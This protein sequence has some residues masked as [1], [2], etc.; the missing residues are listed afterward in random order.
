MQ[1]S[2][3]IPVYNVKPYLKEALDSV[4]NQTHK[5][6]EII[7]V[8][9]GSTDGSEAICKEY[10]KK[11][12]RVRLLHQ[13]NKGLSAARNAGLAAMSSE[14][15]AFLDSDDKYHPEYIASMLSIMLSE[16]V[17]LVICQAMIQYTTEEIKVSE[18]ILAGRLPAGTYDRVTSLQALAESKISSTAWN[19]LYKKDLFRNVRFHEGHIYEDGEVAFR[20]INNCSKVYVTNKVLYYY[21]RRPGSITNSCLLE[22]IGDLDLANDRIEAFIRDYIPEIFTEDHVRI[23]R[24]TQLRRMILIYLLTINLPRNKAR[25]KLSERIIDL[26]S[27]VGTDRL[28][29]QD[30]IIW[31]M[32]RHCPVLITPFYTNP[33]LVNVSRSFKTLL[34]GIKRLSGKYR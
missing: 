8:D 18:N 10:E 30:R 13:E 23:K 16:N 12:K 26:G 31:R 6:L 17:D 7:I 19:R 5:E 22:S 20:I 29:V 2:V 1:V 4:I 9:D 15:L 27:R 11:D 21:R 24:Q 33:K 32:I 25:K 28:G 34:R 3:I 14:L